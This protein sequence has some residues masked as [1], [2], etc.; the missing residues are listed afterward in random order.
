MVAAPALYIA[1]Q[2]FCVVKISPT[3]AQGNEK[4][5]A[6]GGK[7]GDGALDV[8]QVF[9]FQTST[10]TNLATMQEAR[11]SHGCA[12]IAKGIHTILENIP[13]II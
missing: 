5:L 13:V 4:L 6:T 12:R 10:W 11:F 8:A 1:M 7:N 9:D 3:A 2:S